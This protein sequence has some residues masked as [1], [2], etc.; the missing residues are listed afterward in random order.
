MKHNIQ[1]HLFAPENV[2]PEIHEKI[3]EIAEILPAGACV[4]GIWNTEEPEQLDFFVEIA[5]QENK[6]FNKFLNAVATAQ[7][8]PLTIKPMSFGH[9]FSIVHKACSPVTEEQRERLEA[10]VQ[11]I[12]D[13]LEVGSV[14]VVIT[15]DGTEDQDL[16]D[17]ANFT[18]KDEN[19]KVFHYMAT[20]LARCPSDT[21]Q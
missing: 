5:R 18:V 17:L 7:E 15:I 10:C 2:T 8:E 6:N 11:S 1:S 21:L 13:L 19:A 14:F 20:R 12:V 3:S 4:F 16:V 9:Q